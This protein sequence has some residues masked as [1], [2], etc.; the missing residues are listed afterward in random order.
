MQDPLHLSRRER[1]IME[2][3]YSRAECSAR[4]VADALPDP[5]SRT[6]VR[7][8]LR[9]LEDKGH[10]THR[11]QGRE[12]LYRPVRARGSVARTALRR[13]LDTFFAGSIERAVAAHLADPRTRL[14][15]EE[16]SRLRALIADA[17][18]DT[19]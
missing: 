18:G 3:V 9:I 16:L 19:P 12:F 17:P 14:S 6:A 10:L 13:L 2:I 4:Q 1:Q 15:E 11:V 8:L 5:P 7:T